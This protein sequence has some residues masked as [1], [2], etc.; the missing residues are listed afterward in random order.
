MVHCNNSSYKIT[1]WGYHCHLTG[2]KVANGTFLVVGILLRNL[3]WFG[4]EMWD[5]NPN[6]YYRYITVL[7]VWRKWSPQV[8][9]GPKFPILSIK[10][11][12]TSSTIGMV[13]PSPM[14]PTVPNAIIHRSNGFAYIKNFH[15]DTFLSFRRTVVLSV[16]HLDKSCI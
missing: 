5:M 3:T 2:V 13:I 10:L 16:L 8:D 4:K 14:V 1:S 9:L 7:I 6:I 11:L 12:N 15:I